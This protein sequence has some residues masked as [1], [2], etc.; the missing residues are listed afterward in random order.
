[1]NIFIT[2]EEHQYLQENLLDTTILIGSKMYGTDDGE[3]DTDYLCIVKPILNIGITE[4]YNCFPNIHQFQYKDLDNKIDY[5]YTTELQFYKNMYSGDSTIN[6]DVCIFYN[7]IPVKNIRTYK[8][9][10]AYLGFAKR[11]IKFLKRDKT[12]LLKNIHELISRMSHI[13]RGLYIAECLLENKLPDLVYIKKFTVNIKNKIATLQNNNGD[14]VDYIDYF[15]SFNS[16]TEKM[17]RENEI[18]NSRQIPMYPDLTDN[19]ELFKLPEE[20]DINKVNIRMSLIQKLLKS[21]N[22][23]EFKY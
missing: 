12:K 2:E 23:I 17:L 3:S 5:I 6:T 4:M 22:I 18:L 1:M 9:I 15:I 21:N 8:I 16:E 13:E 11:D 20:D 7:N 19:I 10:K 14:I